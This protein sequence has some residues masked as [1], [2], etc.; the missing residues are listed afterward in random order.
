MIVS[1]SML[2]EVRYSLSSS[3]PWIVTVILNLTAK[4]VDFFSDVVSQQDGEILISLK[5]ILSEVIR[6]TTVFFVP[7]LF[8]YELT[9][10]SIDIFNQW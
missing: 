8:Y 4:V 6:F 9:S 1:W 2:S 3:A 10:V 5:V 7:E